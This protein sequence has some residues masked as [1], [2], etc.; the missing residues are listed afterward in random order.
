MMVGGRKWAG[1]VGWGVGGPEGAQVAEMTVRSHL[2]PGFEEQAVCSGPATVRPPAG[3]CRPWCARPAPHRDSCPAAKQ[4]GASGT[5]PH[6]AAFS[7]RM[8]G[9][10]LHACHLNVCIACVPPLPWHRLRL[11]FM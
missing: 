6:Q 2:L 4:P 9:H 11:T 8:S 10:M 3:F 1:G 7:L 5:L